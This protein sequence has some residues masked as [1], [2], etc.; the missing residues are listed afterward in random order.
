M[1][2]PRA[3]GPFRG[4]FRGGEQ[5]ESNAISEWQ[6]STWL[7]QRV[8]AISKYHSEVWVDYEDTNG[9]PAVIVAATVSD[10]FKMWVEIEREEGRNL[11]APM[12]HLLDDM[13]ENRKRDFFRWSRWEA[14]SSDWLKYIASVNPD[15][16]WDHALVSE[17]EVVKRSS[18]YVTVTGVYFLI[19]DDRVVYVGK[20]NDVHGRLRRHAAEK[21]FDRVSILRC[22]TNIIDAL[23]AI[24]IQ[25]FRPEMN[26]VVP[27]LF[28]GVS[29]IES[30]CEKIAD[31]VLADGYPGVQ[32]VYEELRNGSPRA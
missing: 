23:E 4:S 25:L 3:G 13:I 1:E 12:L 26:S 14:L 17:S 6:L 21:E 18:P 5:M 19:R 10:A 29:R 27:K 11:R 7:D 31:A 28:S 9:E 16:N 2:R 30:T 32:K 15:L 24:Y 8:I 22:P 20:S